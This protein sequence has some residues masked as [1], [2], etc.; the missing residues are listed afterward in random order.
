MD[1]DQTAPRGEV[2]SGP[3]LFAKMNFEITSR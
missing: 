2:G 3:K 1:P